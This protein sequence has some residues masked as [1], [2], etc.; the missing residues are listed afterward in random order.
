MAGSFGFEKEKYEVSARCG[1][2]GLLPKVRQASPEALIVANGF[3]CQEQVA[4]MTDRHA[5]HL[6]QVLQ[7]AFR[8]EPGN[9]RYPEAEVV[10]ARKAAV[11]ASMLRAGLGIAA[12][13]MLGMGIGWWR[14]NGK[15]TSV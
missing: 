12:A 3:S 15:H 8:G 7:M 13:G 9:G 5:L 11:N 2:L 6:A 10:Q 1:E 14:A 4:Q